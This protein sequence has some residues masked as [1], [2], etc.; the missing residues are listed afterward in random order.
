MK[1][2][3]TVASRHGSSDE[4]AHAI[5]STLAGRGLEVDVRPPDE[6]TDLAPYEAVIVG[7]GVYVG[8]WLEPGRRFV[9]QNTEAL[10]HRPVWLFSVGPL[11]DPPYPA[12]EPVDVAALAE[13]VA[14]RGRT[15]FA[16]KLGDKLGLGERAIVRMV[17]APR[18]D[19]RDWEAIEQW[20]DGIA[21]ALVAEDRGA[22][23]AAAPA[24]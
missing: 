22:A 5:A 20:A 19:F 16:G 14:A 8:R 12:D 13:R 15:V 10:R 23:L 17:K 24:R 4:V 3:L 21:A 6:V 11:G 2:L 7:S 1:V 9:E 18:G